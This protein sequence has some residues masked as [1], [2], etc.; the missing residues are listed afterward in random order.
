MAN[1]LP[2]PWTKILEALDLQPA[3]LSV[4]TTVTCPFCKNPQCL[5]FV[6]TAL[7][8]QWHS[9]LKCGSKGTLLELA[10]KLWKL[11]EI[12]AVQKLA[13]FLQKEAKVLRFHH[14]KLWYEMDKRQQA[15]WQ[16]VHN[17]G[18]QGLADIDPQT[19]VLLRKLKLNWPKVTAENL[20]KGPLELIGLA[21]VQQIRQSLKIEPVKDSFHQLIVRTPHIKLFLGAG[22]KKALI[23]PFRVNAAVISG[24]Q[25]AGRELEQEPDFPFYA[26]TRLLKP[27]VQSDDAGFM[28]HPQLWL[29]GIKNGTILA[30]GDIWLT[31]QLLLK[32]ISRNN[33]TLPLA[34]W[35]YSKT[36]FTNSWYNFLGCRKIVWGHAVTPELVHQAI[37]AKGEISLLN[38][39]YPT[40]AKL[41]ELATALQPEDFVA[42][43]IQYAKP[44]QEIVEQFILTHQ[45]YEIEELFLHLQHY[46]VNIDEIKKLLPHKSK[47]QLQEIL[48]DVEEWP[49]IKID[50]H[51]VSEREDGWYAENKKGLALVSDAKFQITQ[52]IYHEDHKK[53]RYT[54]IITFKNQT[55]HFNSLRNDVE[56][57]TKHWLETFLIQNAAELPH[58]S[59][60]WEKSLVDIAKQFNKP[61]VCTVPT[62]V[63][64]NG[65]EEKLQLANFA[66]KLEKV[67]TTPKNEAFLPGKTIPRPGDLQSYL[68]EE[69]YQSSAV[70]SL[71]SAILTNLCS[72]IWDLPKTKI[73]L[74]GQ[75]AEE[76]CEAI[77]NTLGFNSFLIRA[78]SPTRTEI[79]KLY[80]HDHDLPF[81][82]RHSAVDNKDYWSNWAQNL[83]PH[84]CLTATPPVVATTLA[85]SADWWAIPVTE[86]PKFTQN[87]V[88][89]FSSL[90]HRFSSRHWQLQ[91][92]IA[93]VGMYKFLA[94]TAEEFN[95]PS[96]PEMSLICQN[97]DRL[98]CFLH[99]IFQA[100]DENRLYHIPAV[101]DVGHK[102]DILYDDNFVRIPRR[103]K[104]QVI[105]WNIPFYSNVAVNSYLIEEQLLLPE[106]TVNYWVIDRK[107]W[108]AE[109]K[110]WRNQ[111]APKLKLLA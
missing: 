70:L 26:G 97:R 23:V 34:A 54:G 41:Q 105:D 10:A 63:G 35:K 57:R 88:E 61:K 68:L 30:S 107:W 86:M 60:K 102:Q 79:E 96:I 1:L 87:Y 51:T 58:V 32:S 19:N 46:N 3:S 37:L 81:I 25:F 104:E 94:A 43:I 45:D 39:K 89:A 4:P 93:V 82:A 24:F 74:Y 72:K 9:C 90:L 75:Y 21:D 27:N 8:G 91:H 48:P 29:N 78:F 15:A 99:L 76:L 18:K 67:K 33:S 69:V 44:W 12:A 98:R 65:E 14:G 56:K 16:E 71:T 66:L 47:T 100:I 38:L 106:T 31:L 59:K 40:K 111:Y 103:W 73:V 77:K 50:E 49:T 5:I 11:S 84:Y 2:V 83:E 52:I 109:R 20:H 80:K 53:I 95:L 36:A 13:R 101:T 22:W 85:I 6:D 7:S 55:W 28:A 110:F 108:D 42:Q 64:W 17:L 92:K 62:R